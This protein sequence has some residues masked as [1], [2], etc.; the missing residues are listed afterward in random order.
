VLAGEHAW[1]ESGIVD[2]D[3]TAVAVADVR[4]A[5]YAS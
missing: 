4:D 2:E 5:V 1:L 3:V